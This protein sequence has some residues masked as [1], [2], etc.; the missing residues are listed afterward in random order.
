V[1]LEVIN[2]K[3]LNVFYTDKSG[4]LKV[5]RIRG[6]LKNGYFV[7]K[8]KHYLFLLLLQISIGIES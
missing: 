5:K 8:R 4:E 2:N 6:K 3:T 1:R 7:L